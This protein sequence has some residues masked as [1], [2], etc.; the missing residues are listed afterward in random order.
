MAKEP[1]ISAFWTLRLIEEAQCGARETATL[2]R[3]AGI[4][5]ADARDGRHISDRRHLRVWD[6]ALRGARRE[7]FPLD[8]ARRMTL[9][10]YA[11][12]ALACKTA[13]DLGAALD[14]IARYVR[15]HTNAVVMTLARSSDA[16]RIRLKRAGPRTA[17]MNAAMTS[18]VAELWLALTRITARRPALRRVHFAHAPSGDVSSC[19]AFF[20]APIAHSSSFD[21]LELG[22]SAE[23]VPIALADSGLYRHLVGELEGALGRAAES[24]AASEI[25]RV[26][27]DVFAAGSSFDPS[28]ASIARRMGLGARTLQRR[29][30]DEGTTLSAVVRDARKVLAG[31]LLRDRRRSVAEVAFL[32]GFSETP[33]FHRA[34]R[35]WYGTTPAR[36][37]MSSDGGP[38][39]MMSKD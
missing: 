4:T 11:V 6:A 12:L 18:A 39:G 34:F 27:L 16:L 9:D 32:L 31:D 15:I 21:G 35:R 7:S 28:L 36:W 17:A 20:A 2:W 37:T 8:V 23:S 25:H 33:A 5:P 3:V 14:V 13:P 1:T 22:R 10:D 24:S 26:L 30:A 29:L 38:I 19:R